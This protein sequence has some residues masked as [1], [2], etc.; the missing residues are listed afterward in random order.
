MQSF[1][2]CGCQ[3]L[4]NRRD[5]PKIH[6]KPQKILNS[7]G[8]INRKKKAEVIT[9]PDFKEQYKPTVM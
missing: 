9:L 1:S 3:F 4:K 5:N 6:M 7:Q 2:K 8:I